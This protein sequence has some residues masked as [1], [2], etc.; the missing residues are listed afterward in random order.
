MLERTVAKDVQAEFEG[1]SLLFWKVVLNHCMWLQ[2]CFA[3]LAGER[4]SGGARNVESKKN[5]L[6]YSFHKDI[7]PVGDALCLE[8][9][10]RP[11]QPSHQCFENSQRNRSTEMI[12]TSHGN[13]GSSSEYKEEV[14]LAIVKVCDRV[15]HS[16][17]LEE[18]MQHMAE[19]QLAVLGFSGVIHS[20]GN[21]LV[22]SSSPDLLLDM[23]SLTGKP[24]KVAGKSQPA[25]V[26]WLHSKKANILPCITFFKSCVQPVFTGR[27]HHDTFA[28]LT[29]ASNHKENA[30]G[31]KETQLMGLGS[32]IMF[33]QVKRVLTRQL[34][35]KTKYKCPFT[36]KDNYADE[37]VIQSMLLVKALIRNFLHSAKILEKLD[38]IKRD[39]S[40][41]Y[42]QA[43]GAFNIAQIIFNLKSKWFQYS[44]RGYNFL[45]K[46]KADAIHTL[47]K[48]QVLC[49]I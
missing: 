45:L 1:I 33:Q 4:T 40:G 44:R 49:N 47:L 29:G 16:V 15:K 3:H 28:Y 21:N 24:N 27:L 17:Q 30:T 35:T 2:V 26:E 43:V 13:S 14:M 32:K 34:Q 31:E 41:H 36:V 46:I 6:C 38:E 20:F 11:S 8:L 19:K 37:V 39:V 42:K 25:K 48:M 18:L 10:S 7:P 12:L 9:P 23:H 5:P 22:T